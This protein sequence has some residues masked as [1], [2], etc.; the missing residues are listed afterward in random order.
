MILV[1]I[2]ARQHSVYK[3]RLRKKLVRLSIF[4]AD[5]YI[6]LNLFL[7]FWRKKVLKISKTLIR[8]LK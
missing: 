8:V 3:T 5:I 6:Y 4:S 7:Y 1:A 2:L